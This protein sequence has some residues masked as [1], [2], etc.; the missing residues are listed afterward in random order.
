MCKKWKDSWWHFLLYPSPRH[1][2]ISVNTTAVIKDRA[3]SFVSK[4][5]LVAFEGDKW[6]L[7]LSFDWTVLYYTNSP[8]MAGSWADIIELFKTMA[9][10]IYSLSKAATSYPNGWPVPA[11]EQTRPSL[12]HLCLHYVFAFKVLLLYYACRFC[13]M[14][15]QLNIISRGL[16]P[17]RSSTFGSIRTNI[18]DF[19][20]WCHLDSSLFKKE[21]S[22]GGLNLEPWWGS[23]EEQER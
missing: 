5:N 10:H 8:Y 12:F 1:M 9:C 20:Y 16:V 21:K 22:I 17:R 18:S 13:K 6:L 3:Q 19:V 15:F 7:L 4:Y 14:V 2:I 11:N 23:G